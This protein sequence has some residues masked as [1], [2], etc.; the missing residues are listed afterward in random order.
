MKQY[1]LETDGRVFLIKENG[2]YV[3][4]TNI[5][6]IPFSFTEKRTIKLEEQR[7]IYCEPELDK[8]PSD[9]VHKEDVPLRDDVGRV[10]RKAVNYSLPRIVVEAIIRNEKDEVLMVKPSR[11]YN[12]DGWT[13][14]GGFLVYGESPEQAVVR[15]AVEEISVEPNNLKLVDVFSA[16]GKQNSYQWMVFFYRAQLPESEEV[17]PSHEIKEIKWFQRDTAVDAIHS[18]VMRQ[19]FKQA[20]KK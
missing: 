17:K 11:G 8:H 4:P 5:E 18:P 15:E 10:V 13:L 14:P 2:L 3:F 16:I 1:Y 12:K 7:I 19:G 6:E 9:W 20:W